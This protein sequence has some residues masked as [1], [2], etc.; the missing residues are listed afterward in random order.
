[1]VP[2][3]DVTY[4]QLWGNIKPVRVLAGFIFVIQLKL[5]LGGEAKPHIV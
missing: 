3:K 5:I 2:Y 4:P 1:M